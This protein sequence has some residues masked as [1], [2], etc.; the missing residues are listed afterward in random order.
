MEVVIV[1][2]EV[3]ALDK[4]ANALEVAA[5]SQAEAE[6]A[7]ESAAI[8]QGPSSSSSVKLTAANV[9]APEANVRPA[10]EATAAPSPQVLDPDNESHDTLPAG[11][12][13]D[14]EAASPP[15]N[16]FEGGAQ[17]RQ[18]AEPAVGNGKQAAVNPL[19]RKLEIQMEILNV[20]LSVLQK[21][22][23][24]LE[25]AEVLTAQSKAMTAMISLLYKI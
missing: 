15:E 25:Q 12:G 21:D 13:T 22:K 14:G 9:E 17:E 16:P 10:D 11:V 19:V 18:A 5:D 3:I 7:P 23:R 1:P 24:Y 2:E 6:E 8:P 20:Q 4:V